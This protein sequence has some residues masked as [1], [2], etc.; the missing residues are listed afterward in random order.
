MHESPSEAN[1]FFGAGRCIIRLLQMS[2]GRTLQIE[3]RVL[4]ACVRTTTLLTSKH[5]VLVRLCGVRSTRAPKA[6]FCDA[7]AI[8]SEQGP[9]VTDMVA[10]APVG[11][12]SEPCSRSKTT[13]L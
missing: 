1:V 11:D 2:D 7:T 8:N 6:P 4:H 3:R 13:L 5:R 12:R 9:M 10:A